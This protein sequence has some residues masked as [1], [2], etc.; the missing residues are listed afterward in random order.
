MRAVWRNVM[1]LVLVRV[2]L[3]TRPAVVEAQFGTCT[4]ARD[5]GCFDDCASTSQVTIFPDAACQEQCCSS[6]DGLP[7]EAA[8]VV[9]AQ[10]CPN[11]NWPYDYTVSVGCTGR[12]G[13]PPC[14]YAGDACNFADLTCC[15]D[16]GL[17]CDGGVC[18]T[19]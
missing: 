10:A 14:G 3:G 6:W 4:A 16:A 7:G 15:A 1:F 11:P 13:P 5:Y 17:K 9:Q 12:C 19:S 18:V 2:S 8:C